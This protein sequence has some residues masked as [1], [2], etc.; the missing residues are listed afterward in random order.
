MTSRNPT[1]RTDLGPVTAPPGVPRREEEEPA[2]LLPLLLP[3]LWLLLG[4]VALGEDADL[5]LV[6]LHP[7]PRPRGQQ[8]L[9]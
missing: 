6:E 7:P 5:V 1:R 4:L 2:A 9:P 3:L 8:L